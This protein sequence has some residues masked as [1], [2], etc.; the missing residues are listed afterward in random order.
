MFI[1]FVANPLA[2][3]QIA[4]SLPFTQIHGRETPSAS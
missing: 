2:S 3:L 4:D 1:S